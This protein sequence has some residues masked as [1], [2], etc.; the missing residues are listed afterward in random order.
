MLPEYASGFDPR[1]VGAEHAEPLDGPFVTMLR[2]AREGDRRGG[3]GRHD[4]ARRTA[5]TPAR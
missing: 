3:A 4:A 1:G 5:T 2:D